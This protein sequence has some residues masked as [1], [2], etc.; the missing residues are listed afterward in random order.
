MF[1]GN[2]IAPR[3]VIIHDCGAPAINAHGEVLVAC[4]VDDPRRAGLFLGDGTTIVP[5]ALQG[6][7]APTGAIYDGFFGMPRLNDY[8]DVAFQALLDRGARGIFRRIGGQTRTVAC[9]GMR[10]PGTTGTF[11]FFGREIRLHNDGRVAFVGTLTVGVGGVTAANNVGIWIGTSAEHLQLV[12][13]TGDVI[14]GTVLTRLPFPGRADVQQLD[15]NES[16]LAWIGGFQ[17]GVKAVVL[18]RIG[19]EKGNDAAQK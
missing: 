3:G 14:E 2:L 4:L 16:A 10:A 13:R 12:V 6:D 1:V 7:A 9:T 17:S 19:D 15:M 11:Q 18:T 8:G 5:I